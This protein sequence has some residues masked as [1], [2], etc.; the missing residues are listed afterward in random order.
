MDYDFAITGGTVVDGTGS[1]RRTADVAIVGDRIAAIGPGPFPATETI[2]ATG[3]IVAPGF[4]D[5]H[6]HADFT[7]LGHPGAETQLAQGVT[8]LVTGNCG[9]SPFPAHDSGQAGA[10]WPDAY[11]FGDAVTAARPAVNVGLQLG[12]NTLRVAVIG[13]EDRPPTTAEL[14]QMCAIITESATAPG[15][16]GFSTGLIY[17]P[18]LFAQSDELC[19][20][21]AAAATAGLLYSTHMRNETSELAAAVE[22][23]I[24]TAERAGARLQI[25]HLKAMGPEN[26]GTVNRALEL[27]DQARIRGVDVTADVYPYTAS[28]TDLSSRLARWAV[29]G[30][31]SALL[32]RLAD[33]ETRI[34]IADEL[35]SRFGRDIDPDGVV[36]AALPSGEFHRYIGHSLSEI[37]ADRGTDAADAALDV[38]AAHQGSVSIVNHAMSEDDMRSVLAHPQVSVA[39]DGAMLAPAG[40]GRPHPRSFGTFARVLGRYVRDERTLT[41]ED[42]I[43]KMTSLPASRI[44]VTDRGMLAPSM[45]ADVV[46][47]DPNT[48]EDTSTFDAPWQLARGVR[49]VFVNGIPTVSGGDLTGHRGGRLLER[50]AS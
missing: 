26:W 20:L 41:L 1:P 10:Q 28:S 36:I 47:L 27:M 29:D 45:A 49:D 40:P 19:T 5:L 38:L 9:L 31:L 48:I 25:S 50:S 15:V 24:E 8:T 34:R 33:P 21:V 3:C 39:S 11:G 32:E 12:H 18:G 23:A 17:I 30:G 16:V 2:D 46:I 7:V 13:N 4:I 22:E 37:G 6:S 42:A 14:E 44:R 43:R 35:R